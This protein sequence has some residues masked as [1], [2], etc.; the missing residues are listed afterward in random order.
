MPAPAA[1]LDECTHLDL[2]D[3]LRRRGFSVTSLQ[4]VGPRGA[5]DDLVLQRVSELG[6]VLVTHNVSDFKAWH[7]TFQRQGRAHG[8]IIGLPQTRPFRRLEHRVAMMLDWL[9]TQPYTSRLFLWG[10]L[11]QLLERG[12]RLPGY[13]DDEVREA[14]GQS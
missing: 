4:I 12:F 10:H 6:C 8:G 7:A 3:T 1:C 9:G 14:L 11:Q 13:S 5:T 2:V